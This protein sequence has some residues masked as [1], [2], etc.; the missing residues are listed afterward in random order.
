MKSTNKD[1]V[2]YDE[3]SKTYNATISINGHKINLGN[4]RYESE[5]I[6][7]YNFH[8]EKSNNQQTIKNN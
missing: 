5:A 1:G 8:I 7:S 4:F 6:Q 3:A 2:K